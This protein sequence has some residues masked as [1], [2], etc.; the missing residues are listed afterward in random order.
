MTDLEYWKECL[1]TVT[2]EI[3]LV[4]LDDELTALAKAASSGHECYGMAFYSPPSSDR[5]AQIDRDWQAKYAALEKEFAEYRHGAEK[6]MRR[7]LPDALYPDATIS[8]TKDGKVYS[9]DGRTHLIVG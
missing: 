3:P 8:I 2:E 7:A 6:A 4:L 9:H 1:A 5:Y